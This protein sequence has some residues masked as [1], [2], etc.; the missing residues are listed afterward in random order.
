MS[1]AQRYTVL[2]DG[3]NVIKRHAP[4]QRLPLQDGRQRLIAL[5]KDA[6]WPVAISRIVVVFDARDPDAREIHP[7]DNLSI[8]FAAPSA[9][10]CIQDL[11]R[12]HPASRFLVISDDQEIL[13]TAKSHGA[14]RYS[15]GWL[16]QRASPLLH[17][18]QAQAPDKPAL[19]AKAARQIT[20]ELAKRWLRSS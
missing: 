2:V 18:S 14:K 17:P 3:Y 20:E 15:A 11:I 6:R 1:P 13:G 8:R 12:A 19:P 16:F 9:D 4:W 10:A 7:G 5:L